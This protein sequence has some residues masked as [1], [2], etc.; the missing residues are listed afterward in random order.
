MVGDNEALY[1]ITT[2]GTATLYVLSQIN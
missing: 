2:A 1:A